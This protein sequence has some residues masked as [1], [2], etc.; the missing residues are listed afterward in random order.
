ML[1][2]YGI[3][4]PRE[5]FPRAKQAAKKALQI[6]DT[7]AEA[8]NALAYAAMYYDWNWSEAEREFKLAI[9]LSPN[10]ALSR[11]WYGL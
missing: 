7:V 11:Q 10:Y 5:A 1:P 4:S 8:H 9:T 3:A 2:G 6:D